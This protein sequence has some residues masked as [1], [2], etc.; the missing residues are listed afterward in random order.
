[1]IRPCLAILRDS[2]REALASHV[3][4]I[5]LGGILAVLVG[6]SPFG[7]RTDR[8]LRLRHDELVDPEGL[9]AALHQGASQ[10]GTPAAHL[11]SLLTGAQQQQIAAWQKSATAER[12]TEDAATGP[13]NRPGRRDR[14]PKTQLVRIINE[15]LA[16]TDYCDPEVWRGVALEDDLRALTER[17][18]A[19]PAERATRNLRLL[20]A[21]FP[22]FIAV[23]D[24]PATTLTYAGADVIG[25]ID[26]LPAQFNRLLDQ[27][28]ISVLSVF[29]GFLGVMGSLL[30]T[31]SLLPRT[32]EPGEISL[33]L[34]K[35]ISRSLLFLTK[36]FGGCVFTL[37]CSAL[38]I[39]GLWLL[40]GLR[41]GLWRHEL[42]WC[43]PIYVFLFAIYFSV[44][45]VTGVIWRSPIVSL[46]LVVFFWGILT[47]LGVSRELIEQSL[48]RAKGIAAITVGHS[49][50]GSVE[51]V[52]VVDGVNRVSRWD[53]VS[54]DWSEIFAP[55]GQ[56]MPA[57][58]QRMMS[59]GTRFRLMYDASQTRILA[60]Q[61]Q[62]SRFGGAAPASIVSG[63]AERNWEREVAGQT[64]EPVFGLFLD[65]SGRVILPGRRGIY[66]FLGQSEAQTQAQQFF[67]NMFGLLPGAAGAK[68][69]RELQPEP[70]PDWAPGAVAALDPRHDS[71]IIFSQGTVYRL[72][73]TADGKYGQGP[74]RSLN[75]TETAAVA[76]A[77]THILLALGDG[78]ILMLHQ[79]T[80]ET[81][82]ETRLSQNA[83]PRTAEAAP[84]GSRFA[85]LDHR[86]RVLVFEAAAARFSAWAPAENGNISAVAF[87]SRQRMIVANGRRT[88]SFY[89]TAGEPPEQ[90]LAGAEHWIYPVYDYV[91]SPLHAMLPKPSD[92]DHAITWL[93]TGER[94]V[95]SGNNDSGPFGAA[96]RD[97]LQQ[98]RITFDLW[99]V[100]RSNL[101]FI[102]VMLAAGCWYI[103]RRDF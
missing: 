97:N 16:K 37:L 79:A 2:F 50:D 83:V 44:S 85:V 92:M 66:E 6:I 88:L 91:I 46:I 4:W 82:A 39:T 73:R 14:S 25:P 72:D 21:G 67:R 76:V 54:R 17:D 59:S 42:L 99:S 62:P 1:M 63:T 101:A 70:L 78:R 77:G 10:S 20:N 86:G 75:T 8:S 26:A 27:V 7:L 3:L 68:N 53:E 22:R 48:I 41:V 94:A 11:W 28:I 93:V 30:V 84:D 34:S 18:P 100:F 61:A 15:L 71:L 74:S 32:F 95:V 96:D 58:L 24:D 36:Y 103:S 29:L 87:D 23:R 102:A 60:L 47:T 52:F 43:I 12:R 81:V 64:P 13:E 98:D 51:D 5:A 9:V 33:L 80:L 55:S 65:S 57:F 56:S 89:S 49:T 45:A 19:E 31:A 90:V 40:L 35:P 69:F 38:L